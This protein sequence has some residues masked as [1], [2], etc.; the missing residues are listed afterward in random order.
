MAGIS[1]HASSKGVH[2]SPGLESS[3][4]RQN[5]STGSL[6]AP[7]PS[8]G[9]T[10]TSPLPSPTAS[11]LILLSPQWPLSRPCNVK[12]LPPSSWS[13]PSFVFYQ[14]LELGSSALHARA[15]ALHDTGA[16]APYWGH[17]DSGDWV[18]ETL[19]CH[20]IRAGSYHKQW[21]LSEVLTC[22]FM[23]DVLCPSVALQQLPMWALIPHCIPGGLVV[24][25]PDS[26]WGHSRPCCR[27][28]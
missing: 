27:C 15:P 10:S 20:R 25:G 9:V 2:P 19:A 4:K 18:T 3:L 16:V 11:S 5:G 13:E 1:L 23:S 14:F 28:L 6:G 7:L 12:L 21:L 17:L 26:Q 8:V 22:P 24:Y